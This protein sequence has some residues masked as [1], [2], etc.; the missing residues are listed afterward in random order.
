MGTNGLLSWMKTVP[1]YLS[2]PPSSCGI[3]SFIRH[4]WHT[5][6]TSERRLCPGTLPPGSSEEERS[7]V[8]SQEEETGSQ[9]KKEWQTWQWNWPQRHVKKQNQKYKGSVL[10]PLK[11]S[12]GPWQNF[13]GQ[14]SESTFRPQLSFQRQRNPLAHLFPK[15][16]G[17]WITPTTTSFLP[18]V[19]EKTSGP[20]PWGNLS[21]PFNKGS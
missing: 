15:A 7:W 14:Y 16:P 3:Q 12:H 20:T 18:H 10:R 9:N 6:G 8:Y 1:H 5:L 13:K 2:S 11:A 17:S 4:T 21:S 19:P